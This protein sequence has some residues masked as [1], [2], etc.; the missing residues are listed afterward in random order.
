MYGVSFNPEVTLKALSYF[1]DGNL[2]ELAEDVK[3][4]LVA[5]AREV[6]L[7]HLPPLAP[8]PPA[9]ENDLGLEL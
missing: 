1:E 6:D 7:E 9:L 2:R 3:Q 4:R 5:A 8:G